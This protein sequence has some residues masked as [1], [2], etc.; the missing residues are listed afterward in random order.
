MF[1][2]FKLQYTYTLTYKYSPFPVCSMCFIKTISQ[3]FQ[4]DFEFASCKRINYSSQCTIINCIQINK[5]ANFPVVNQKPNLI[6]FNIGNS[7]PVN[8]RISCPKCIYHGEHQH[9][10]TPGHQQIDL[11]Q[12]RLMIHD[13][14]E[15]TS[16]NC[17]QWSMHFYS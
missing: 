3:R 10:G 2:N 11:R 6:K 12:E 8:L 14:E 4:Q 17:V 13:A 5:C 1:N 15:L 7:F 16:V 9:K